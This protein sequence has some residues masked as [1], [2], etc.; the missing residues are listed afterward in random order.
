[1]H[2]T[3]AKSLPVFLHNIVEI[4]TGVA[5]VQ[6]HRQFIL[7]SEI[8]VERKHCQLLLLGSVVEPVVVESALADGH[9]PILDLDRLFLQT[10]KVLLERC[11]LLFVE[12]L[13][14]PARMNPNRTV[15]IL[16]PLAQL[17]PML[18]IRYIPRSNEQMRHSHLIGPP[19][20]LIPILMVMLVVSEL[21]V[22][23]ISGNIEESKCFG[24]LLPEL[25]H[26]D[27]I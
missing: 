13:V 9:Q 11:M 24:E 26:D 8:E 2:D 3:C 22:R 12:R 6:V 1:M 10:L 18:R 20:H 7:F 4:V 14:R 15:S 19:H 16:I 23:Q 21:L 5:V 25:L 27:M 17:V